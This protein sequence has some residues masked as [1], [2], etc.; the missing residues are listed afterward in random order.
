MRK[1][2]FLRK[3]MKQISMLVLFKLVSHLDATNSR[4]VGDKGLRYKRDFLKFSQCS[5]TGHCDHDT[6]M[7]LY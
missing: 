4:L 3:T 6:L 2:V 7:Q 5:L 1:P